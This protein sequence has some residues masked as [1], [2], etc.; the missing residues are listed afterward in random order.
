M[1]IQLT[2]LFYLFLRLAPFIL[3]SYFTLSSVFHT[4][5]KG[6]VYLIGLLITT[7]IMSLEQGKMILHCVLIILNPYLGV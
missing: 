4:D 1:D 6:F 5:L 7:I 2:A 3:V